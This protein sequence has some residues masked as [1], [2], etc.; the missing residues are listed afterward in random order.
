MKHT[1]EM[2]YF[3]RAIH[4]NIEWDNPDYRSWLQ[5]N[6]L[7]SCIVR[8]LRADDNA[9]SLWEISDNQSNLLD[10]IAAFVSMS[11]GIKD[12]FDYALLSTHYINEINFMPLRKPARTA[13]T[14]FN[15]YHR[16]VPNLSVNQV[17]YFA[18]LLSRHGKFDRMG[19][20]EIEARLKEAH[21]RGQLDLK[22]M[23]PQL[24]KQLGIPE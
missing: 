10:I 2:P 23:K 8:D 13:Y 18:Y 15:H 20:K 19:W 7:P 4:S 22:K 6:E 11:N 9:L 3:L 16:D 14:N 12:D 21:T 24:K 17:V 1:N 5:E